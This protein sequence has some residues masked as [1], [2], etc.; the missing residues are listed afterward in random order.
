M[1]RVPSSEL[2]Y[3]FKAAIH[4]RNGEP[5]T[6]TAY[7]LHAN[8][9]LAEETEFRDGLRWGIS[10][11]WYRDGSPSEERHFLRDVRHGIARDWDKS[12]R[13]EEE[14]C[15]EYGIVVYKKTWNKDGVLVENYQLKE[16]D[17]DF[18]SL[19]QRREAYGNKSSEV[20]GSAST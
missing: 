17:R 12:G 8:G 5:F 6:G 13:L 20:P 11:G 10:R 1:I 3:D 2:E 15:C 18:E 9:N 14:S 16:G 19:Q 7:S 4:L